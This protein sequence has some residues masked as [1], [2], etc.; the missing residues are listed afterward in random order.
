MEKKKGICTVCGRE[1]ELK[2][3]MCERCAD[4][5]NK[6]AR[7]MRLKEKKESKKEVRRQGIP[8]KDN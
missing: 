5:I 1:E 3:I 2:G 7:G 8:D 4:K 6:E